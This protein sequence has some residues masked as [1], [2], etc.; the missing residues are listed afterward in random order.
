MRRREFRLT[1]ALAWL[2][3]LAGCTDQMRQDNVNAALA[4]ANHSAHI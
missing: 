3:L 1:A 4:K 2:F